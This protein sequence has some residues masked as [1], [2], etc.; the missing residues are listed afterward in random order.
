MTCGGVLDP[1]SVLTQLLLAAGALENNLLLYHYDFC[2]VRKAF[3]SAFWYYKTRRK[4]CVRFGTYPGD[5]GLTCTGLSPGGLVSPI[6]RPIHYS[7]L[8]IHCMVA[9]C[10]HGVAAIRGP[11]FSVSCFLVCII[12]WYT[13]YIMISFF[14]STVHIHVFLNIY[15][16]IHFTVPVPRK[17][18][19]DYWR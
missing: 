1:I 5:R 12:R 2:I 15:F 3:A 13:L 17:G 7:F 11:S 14:D 16:Y 18:L 19:S 6:S 8:F 4:G 9:H 10:I